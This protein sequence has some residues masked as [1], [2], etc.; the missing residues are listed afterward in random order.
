MQYNTQYKQ[1]IL[2]EYGRNIQQMVDFCVSIENREERTRCAYTIVKIMSG[3][4]PELDE[5]ENKEHK[6]W[7]HINVMSDF[8]LDVDF[9][10]EDI[11][12]KEN[13]NPHPDRVPYG[14]SRIRYRHYGKSIELMID[15]I[16]QMEDGEDKDILIS[17]VAHHMKKLMLIHNKEGVDDAKILRD[18]A[19]YSNGKI[20]LNPATYILHEFKEAPAQGTAKNSKKKKK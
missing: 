19:E 4:F 16:A 7:D 13:H 1:L 10:Y 2:P 8:K 15:K 18:L 6:L 12:K 9:P 3:L 11:L 20:N 14:A 5:L 17:M